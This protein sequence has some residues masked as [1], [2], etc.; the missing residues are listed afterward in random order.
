MIIA[1][2]NFLKDPLFKIDIYF[3]SILII[4][5]PIAL[6]TGPAVPDIIISII[7]LYFLIN[8]IKKKLW[9]YYKNIF[10]YG[11]FLF[12]LYSFLR[13]IFSD[14]PIV[15]L[16]NNGSIFYFRYLFFVLGFW[17]LIDQNKKLSKYL[18]YSI[19][20]C[21]FI[22]VADGFYQYFVGVNIFGN[23]KWSADRLTGLFGDEP[24]IGRYVAYLSIL[25]FVL[26]YQVFHT[27]KIVTILSILLLVISEIFVFF[28]GE[29]APF[30]Y[31]TFFSILILIYIEEFRMYRILGFIISI[32][33]IFSII[34]YNPTAKERMID[35]TINQIN[36]TQ[37]P[38]LPYSELHER[39]YV[40]AFKMFSQNPIF[41]VG[42]NLFRNLCEKKDFQYKKGSCTSHPHN[43]YIQL[44]AE[45]GIIGFLFLTSFF[46]VL[47]ILMIKQFFNLHLNTKREKINFKN[48]LIILILFVFWW[49]LIPHMSF[50]NNWNNIFLML[51]V[52]YFL[53]YFYG[54]R[55][56]F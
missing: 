12:C 4:L 47:I 14:L 46:M 36:E 22:V 23:Q 54:N 45:L 8:S 49:P 42:T 33:V 53:K 11:F 41:G 40:S 39:H 5:L 1:L 15:S 10:V 34:Y 29:R 19:L 6:I 20:I 26:I 18:L 7:G 28:S 38:Y 2:K 56:N 43:F 25:A 51:P 37:L 3:F 9:N 48:F 27:T 44:L 31:L 55:F 21:C 24:I 32:V 50:Y 30:F 16:T 35:T 52:S 17:Y 13:S